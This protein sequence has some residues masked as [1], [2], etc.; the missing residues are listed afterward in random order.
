[1]NWSKVCT[2]EYSPISSLFIFKCMIAAG[3]TVLYI[4]GKKKSACVT[5][6]EISFRSYSYSVFDL[7]LQVNEAIFTLILKL[8]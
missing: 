5:G 1:M 4:R 2:V 6:L 7:K 3:D 8:C